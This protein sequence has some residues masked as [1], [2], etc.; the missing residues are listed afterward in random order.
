MLKDNRTDWRPSMPLA[1]VLGVV[2]PGSGLLYAGKPKLAVTVLA[3][4]WAVVTV[5]VPWI[6]VDNDP[7]RIVQWSVTA[8]IILTIASALTGG[9][10]AG[11]SRPSTRK[12]YQHL[13]W[14]AGFALLAHVGASQLRTRVVGEHIASFALVDNTRYVIVKGPAKD[15]D[16]VAVKRGEAIKIEKAPVVDGEI[17]GR[18]VAIR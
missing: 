18:A 3:L 13:W 11:L 8:F 12:P 7:A 6:V 15:G 4:F 10:F 9:M 5:G 14:V 1:I 16:D 17:I 2:A